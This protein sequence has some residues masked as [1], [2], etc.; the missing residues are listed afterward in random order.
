[1]IRAEN[2]KFEEQRELIEFM[3]HYGVKVKLV[4]KLMQKSE[5]YIHFWRRGSYANKDLCIKRE[6][7]DDLK[8]KYKDYMLTELSK[9]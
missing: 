6:E 5:S 8:S 9:I 7:L 4:A 1:M 2:A 3:N